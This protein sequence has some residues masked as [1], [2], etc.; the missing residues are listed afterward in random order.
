[1]IANS[2]SPMMVAAIVSAVREDWYE[3][4]ADHQARIC[5]LDRTTPK[6]HPGCPGQGATV[7]GTSWRFPAA[8]ALCR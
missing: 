5:R 4:V 2:V 6:S 7:E 1:M 3:S 8:R